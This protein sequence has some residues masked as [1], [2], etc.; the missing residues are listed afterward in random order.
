MKLY[1]ATTSNKDF[2]Y[3]ESFPAYITTS[4]ICAQEY[5]LQKHCTKS[6]DADLNVFEFEL[7]SSAKIFNPELKEHKDKLLE[8]M[9]NIEKLVET[10]VWSYLKMEG[11]FRIIRQMGFNVIKG[12]WEGQDT[13]A[14]FSNAHIKRVN[15]EHMGIESEIENKFIFDIEKGQ[16]ISIL[17]ENTPV[18]FMNFIEKKHEIVAGKT[19]VDQAY[20]N[21]KIEEYFDLIAKSLSYLAKKPVYKATN[22]ASKINNYILL[23][24]YSSFFE[25][26]P[27]E[28]LDFSTRNIFYL[29]EA[30]EQNSRE[31]KENLFSVT[32]QPYFSTRLNSISTGG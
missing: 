31:A 2:K 25:V 9:Q 29:E 19:I 24:D 5:A 12:K 6:L 30:L 20:S 28:I 11:V 13:Y 18:A 32:S 26:P 16:Y 7:Q 4:C 22:G 10:D 3:F 23:A 14:I 8:Y 1:H 21:Q 15:C 27:A 17:A